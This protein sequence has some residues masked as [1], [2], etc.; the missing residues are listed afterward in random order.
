MAYQTKPLDHSTSE[1]YVDSKANNLMADWTD[2]KEP[3]IKQRQTTY[4][5]KDKNGN[6]T[7]EPKHGTEEEYYYDIDGKEFSEEELLKKARKQAAKAW[8]NLHPDDKYEEIS[9]ADDD[10]KGQKENGS[11]EVASEDKED[12]KPKKKAVASGDL[13]KE[14]SSGD[15]VKALNDKLDELGYGDGNKD[16]NAEYDADAVKKFQ[17]EAG[18]AVD[19]KAGKQ[20]AAALA[21]KKAEKDIEEKSKDGFTAEE[22]TAI[23][24]DLE[25]VESRIGKVSG[26]YKDAVVK[27]G[28]ELIEKAKGYTDISEDKN[29]GGQLANLSKALAGGGRDDR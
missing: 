21:V 17:T 22:K 10:S 16:N 26:K 19:G 25:D 20:T 9:S 11:E 8:N 2:G 1:N 12:K 28:K 4:Y 29:V 3:I 24:K 7:G 5:E 23:A 18:I 15:K 27:I 6:D 13:L 14:G